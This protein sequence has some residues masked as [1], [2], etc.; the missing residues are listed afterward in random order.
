MMTRRSSAWLSVRNFY[1]DY[2]A[3]P[4][5]YGIL[6]AIVVSPLGLVMAWAGFR[7]R[8]HPW[9]DP[10]P[11]VEALAKV[12]ALAAMAFAVTVIVFLVFRVRF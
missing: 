11:F 6:S 7:G 8:F 2:L 3:F 5:R 9:G 4:I 1:T 12:P 10:I